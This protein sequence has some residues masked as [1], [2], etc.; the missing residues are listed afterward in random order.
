MKFITSRT[1]GVVAG[2]AIWGVGGFFAPAPLQAAAARVQ[3]CGEVI[4]PAVVDSARILAAA[5]AGGAGAPVAGQS[6]QQ[7]SP[8]V[9]LQSVA[10]VLRL[11]IDYN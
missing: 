6:A 2:I 3:A 8:E 5:A 9:R 1:A 7:S 11:T 4:N 10:G